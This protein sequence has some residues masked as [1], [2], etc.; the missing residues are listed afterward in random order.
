MRK[1]IIDSCLPG[2]AVAAAA[3]TGLIYSVQ[4]YGSALAPGASPTLAVLN[5]A[6]S[7]LIGGGLAHGYARMFYFENSRQERLHSALSGAF[8]SL[9]IGG[10]IAGVY[11]DKLG[12]A[13]RSLGL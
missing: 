10:V 6:A 1:K 9:A 13:C 8:G 3:G 2:F 11:A 5:T 12:Q 7:F 4:H